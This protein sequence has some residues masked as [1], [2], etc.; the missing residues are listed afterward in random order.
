MMDRPTRTTIIATCLYATVLLIH[1]SSAN[2][3]D[4][5]PPKTATLKGHVI[6]H[7]DTKRPWR[8]GRYYIKSKTIGHLAGA[9]V[10]LQAPSLKT[11]SPPAKTITIDQINFEFTPETVTIRAGDTIRFTNADDALHSV[12][13]FSGRNPFNIT[14]AKGAE[15]LH[16]FDKAGA[17]QPI[18]LKCAFHGAM[19]GW[20]YVFDH[21]F[22]HITSAN[23][24][25]Q[26]NNIPPGQYTL[27][28]THPS[29][30]LAYSKTITLKPGQ[31]LELDIEVSP[32]NL[33]KQN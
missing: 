18:A 26:L 25:Y 20:I 21:P 13:T 10:G 30:T 12:L 6:Y 4:N 29:G 8:L 19:R 5:A 2:A 9:V 32:D 28:M 3:S 22:H 24:A 15:Y 33:L 31:I 11:K 17:F 23:G 7:P 16:R 27:R 14:V 1:P